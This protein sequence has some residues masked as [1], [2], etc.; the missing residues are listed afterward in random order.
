M[1]H[2]EA[3]A[4]ERL[5]SEAER[6]FMSHGF[7]AV[8]TRDICAAARIKQ[9]TLY[10]YFANKEELYLAVTQRWLARFGTGIRGGIAT[11]TTLATQ[12]HAIATLFWAGPAGEYQAMQRDAMLN[13][14]AEHLAT[15]GQMVWRELLAP[16]SDLLKDAIT[17]GELPNYADPVV[18]MQIFWALVDG[19]SGIYRRGDPMPAPTANRA[20][21]DF[22][23][24][25]ARSMRAEDFAQWPRPHEL[26]PFQQRE[27]E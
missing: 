18:L 25:G 21:I 22:F 24:G 20:I 27:S 2:T 1:E 11:N 12:L 23:L 14:P 16:I 9:P 19:V 3:G 7:A 4:R 15:V 13:M 26:E 5:L 17:R 10:H 8:S 6:L